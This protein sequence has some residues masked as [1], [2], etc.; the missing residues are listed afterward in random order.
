MQDTAGEIRTNSLVTFSNDPF[1]TDKKVLDGQ[2]EL[3]YNSSVRTQD[4]A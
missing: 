4:V 2:L 1:Q 3:I